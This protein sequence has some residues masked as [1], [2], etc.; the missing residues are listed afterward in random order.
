MTAT[1]AC[2]GIAVH[3]IVF[4]LTE[5]PILGSKN[6]ATSLTATSGGT[7]VNAAKAIVD[8]GG[9]ALM[10][11][12]VGDDA[13][14]D[15]V[16]A[17]LNARG[18][19][20]RH[21]VRLSGTPTPV[22]SVMLHRDG[23]RT[24]VNATDRAVTQNAPRDTSHAVQAADAVLVDVR[25]AEGALAAVAQGVRAAKPVVVDF[26]ISAT[27]P[28]VQLL[29]SASHVVFS[30]G[31]LESVAPGTSAREALLGVAG[32][33]DAT[34]GVTM[35]SHGSMWAVNGD[36]VDIP[37]FDTR[38]VNT[39]GAGDVFHGA[40]VLA[41]GE[42]RHAIESAVWASAAAALYCSLDLGSG[43]RLTRTAVDDIMASR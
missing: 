33:T 32:S 40:F 17:D 16:M 20:T 22:S 41:I 43:A 8:L 25:W 6:F 19:D 3:D 35:G 13:A 36:I 23:E 37:A 14:G 4:H 12:V 28:P 2:F 15:A 38:T 10:V 26:D 7:S 30:L 21:V 27:T 5:D 29:D 39:L 31:G 11:S 42:G 9:Q 34:L 18:I 24:I 1:V